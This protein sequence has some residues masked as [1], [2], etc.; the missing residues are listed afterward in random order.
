M[1]GEDKLSRSPKFR[2]ATI[3]RSIVWTHKFKKVELLPLNI[4]EDSAA[5]PLTNWLRPPQI[6][7]VLLPF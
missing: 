1:G 7:E 6:E 2:K 3:G 4:I 5:V